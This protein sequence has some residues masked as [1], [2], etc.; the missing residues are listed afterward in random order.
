[1]RGVLTTIRLENPF[2][3]VLMEMA[4]RASLTTNQLVAAK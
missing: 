4:A 3:E 2:W 1:V